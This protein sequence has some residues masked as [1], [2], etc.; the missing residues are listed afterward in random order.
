VLDK[1]RILEIYFNAIEYG[2]GLYGIGPATSTY[3]DKHPRD[4]TPV[5][6]AFFSTILPNP[7][8]RY[9]QYCD[10]VLTKY[11][12]RKI[13]RILQ[14]MVKRERLAENEYMLASVTPLEFAIRDDVSPRECKQRAKKFLEKKGSSEKNPRKR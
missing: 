3:F 12:K 10:G 11:T 5:E 14:L 1:E 7:K 13:Q 2:P 4:I 6:A 8:K 9:Q